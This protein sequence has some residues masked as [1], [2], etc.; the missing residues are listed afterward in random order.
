MINTGRRGRRL[1]A[2]PA[3][4]RDLPPADRSRLDLDRLFETAVWA[5]EA[6]G[7]FRPR[8]VIALFRAATGL[9]PPA[10]AWHITVLSPRRP[11]PDDLEIFDDVGCDIER[12]L[13]MA[14]A[15][16]VGCRGTKVTPSMRLLIRELSDRLGLSDAEV[17]ELIGAVRDGEPAALAA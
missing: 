14:L 5:A 6:T 10:W 12:R 1:A 2:A 7:G 9:E 15:L 4:G 8:E 3:G 17:T 16:L 11:G 13:I